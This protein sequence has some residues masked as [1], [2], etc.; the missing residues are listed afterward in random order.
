MRSPRSRSTAAW[1]IFLAGVAAGPRAEAQPPIKYPGYFPNFPAPAPATGVEP[2]PGPGTWLGGDGPF[3]CPLDATRS[4]WSFCDAGV[5]AAEATNRQGVIGLGNTIAIATCKDGKFTAQHYF[6]GS[7]ARPRPFFP[8]PENFD[9]RQDGLRFWLRKAFP[10]NNRLYIFAHQ[11]C[12]PGDIV[13]NTKIIRVLNPFDP[14]T[15]W[16]YQILALGV[17]PV[18]KPNQPD[19]PG[20][21]IQFGNEAFVSLIEKYVYT[22]GVTLNHK[23]PE[24]YFGTFQVTALRISLDELDAAPPGADLSRFSQY[25]T[26]RYG[27][28]KPGLFDPD[29]YYKV[30]IP[31]VIGYTTRYNETLRLWQTVFCHDRAVA[32]NIWGQLQPGDPKANSAYVM[33]S[34]SP[35]GPWSQPVAVAKFPEM[36][37]ARANHPDRPFNPDNMVYAVGEQP[38]FE[39]WDGVIVVSYALGSLG[40][41]RDSKNPRPLN[42]IKVY[43]TYAWPAAHPSF[44][45]DKARTG[46]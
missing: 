36:D 9:G 29:D 17:M 33:T 5:G 7:P 25:M 39:A 44:V 2:N 28:W 37:P 32:Q 22:Y 34:S 20:A 18:P 23:T 21:P 12:D 8:D 11:V 43:N 26:A 35:Y 19:P 46:P 13:Y 4:F 41:N 27:E 31:A 30:G 6:R 15:R 1:L 38:A 3:S 24:D 10:Y 45:P 42:D 14:P 40:Q 16:D